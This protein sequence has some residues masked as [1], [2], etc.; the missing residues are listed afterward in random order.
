[1]KNPFVLAFFLFVLIGGCLV[2]PD[3]GMSWD[4]HPQREHGLVSADYVN[5]YFGWD[6]PLERDWLDLRSYKSRHYGVLFQLTCYYSAELLDIKTERGEYLLRHCFGFFIFWLAAIVFYKILRYRF[7]DWRVALLGVI[8]LVFSP[9]IFG[10]A[11]FNPKD[12]V[13]LSAVIFSTYTLLKFIEFKTLKYALLHALTCA[14][15]INVR[16]VG[17]ILPAFTL[18][19]LFFE[20]A[21]RFT[22]KNILF[23]WRQL[24]QNSLIWLVL[25]FLLT[26]GFWPYLWVCPFHNLVEA[27]ETMSK[28]P[29]DGEINLYG[30]WLRSTQLPWYYVPAW[31]G[32]TTPLL[33]VLG[34]LAGLFLIL[35]RTALNFF[36]EKSMYRNRAEMIDLFA[37]GFFIGSIFIVVYKE[38]V[39]YNGWRQM[40]FIYPAFLIMAMVAFAKLFTFIQNNKNIARRHLYTQIC[41]AVIV[42]QLGTVAFFMYQYHPWYHLYF[43]LLSGKNRTERFEMDYWGTAHRQAFEQIA[44][45]DHSEKIKVAS[46]QHHFPGILNYKYLSDELKNRIELVEDFDEADYIIVDY[47][48][49]Y[50]LERRHASKFPFNKE[51]FFDF[52]IEG[53]TFLRVVRTNKS[54]N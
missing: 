45:L 31:L 18:L 6:R 29:W 27:F 42:L 53:D 9:R 1:M 26:V 17:V 24:L 22:T 8:F 50:Y 54:K 19:F 16:I 4:E 3:F 44:K 5:E 39:L 49:R 35:R 21:Q 25:T 46:L 30:N 33:Y 52:S 47:I 7:E 2:L 32:A 34:G 43:G 11:F 41:T 36:L 40:Y 15:V 51:T 20:I 28:Y 14:I 23:T 48:G 10:H 38:S 13:L 12:T 37:F